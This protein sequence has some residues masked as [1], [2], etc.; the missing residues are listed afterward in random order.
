M[1]AFLPPR[2]EQT[3]DRQVN[4][5]QAAVRE[6]AKAVNALGGTP[7]DSDAYAFATGETKVIQHKL[8]R[9]PVG[10]TLIDVTGGYPSFV[11]TA[12]NDKTITIV[13]QNTTTAKF[14]F[15]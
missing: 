7:V 1:R 10:W 15:W 8:G 3:P 12:W 2:I 11:R 14:R 9:Q 5:T 13:S 6:V 4:A